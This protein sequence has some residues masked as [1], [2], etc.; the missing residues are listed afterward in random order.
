MMPI[1]FGIQFYFAT[2][3]PELLV[4]RTPHNAA[5]DVVCKL[6]G[7]PRG[8]ENPAFRLTPCVNLKAPSADAEKSVCGFFRI[9]AVEIV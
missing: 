9:R 1:I 4:R 8:L 6:V 2:K 3:Q 7:D 5:A